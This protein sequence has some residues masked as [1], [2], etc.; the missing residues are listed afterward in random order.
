[1]ANFYKDNPDLQRRLDATP[2]DELLPDL[3][4]GFSG[5]HELAPSSLDEA[6]EQIQMVLETVGEIAAEEIAPY[7]AEVDRV[8]ARLVDGE[9]VYPEPMQRAFKLLADA[10]MLGLT[11]PREFGGMHLPMSAY[12]AVIEV[13]SRADASLMTLYALQGCGETIWRYGSPELHQRYLPG[14]C[15]GELT[16]CMALTEPHAGSALDTVS[17]RAVEEGG[18][19]KLNGN[20][21]FIT[22]GGA[23]VLLVL[24][25]SE[26]GVSGAYGLSLFVVDKG[27]GVEVAK[28]EDKL[29]IHGSATA[30]LNLEDVPGHL[31]GGRGAGLFPVAL[32]LMNNARLEVAS[33]AVG[34]AQAAQMQ[35]V[36]Y[37]SE[38]KQGRRTIDRFP[39]VRTMLFENAVHIEAARAIVLRAAEILDRQRAA[40]LVGDSEAADHY[41]GLAD[42]LTPL[43]K[44]Y[45]SEMANGV[46]SRAL[47]VH[48]GYGYMRDYPVERHLRDARITSIYEGTSEIQVSTMVRPLL[49]DGL[50]LLFGRTLKEAVEPASCAGVIDSLKGSY[51][52]LLRAVKGVR[53][54]GKLA[55][56]GWARLFAD[57]CAD[58]FATLIF[59]SDAAENE[60]AAVL[61]RHQASA[62][63]WRAR[64]VEETVKSEDC[65]PF[66]TE[67]FESVVG[68]YRK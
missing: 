19:W 37:A 2:W 38:R 15:S 28:L 58:L 4:D 25:R 44:Y 33:Q 12:T 16:A 18:A 40:K 17:T 13:I 11:L 60:R 56:Q 51:D 65:L 39:P 36:R 59:V 24:A 61:A 22:N 49:Q 21:C 41:G 53:G 52:S 1:V 35:A 30:L 6:K 62:A 31:M 45:A 67:S 27:A 64:R 7:A 54:A 32:S 47:Q 29:G 14:I 26:E 20:K 5:K 9:V 46:T 50:P 55:W 57:A 34:I 8:G 23:D 63:S 66:E 48:G 42:L 43:A 10:G 68:E 3:E